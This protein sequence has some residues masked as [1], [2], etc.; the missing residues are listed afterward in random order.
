[1]PERKTDM[2]DNENATPAQL[3]PDLAGYPTPEAL[4]AGYRNSS[5][6]GKRQRERAD[7]LEGMLMQRLEQDGANHRQSVPD[8][9]SNPEERLTQFGVPVD[10]LEAY[11]GERINR[12][13]APIANGMQARGRIVAD[14]PDY[15]QFETDVAQFIANDA[16]LSA[17]YPKMFEA[18]PAGAME[19]AFLK[20]GDSRRREVT[21]SSNGT[22]GSPIDA[23][24]PGS[25][26]GESRRA[27]D[28]SQDLRTAYEKFAQT[29]SSK[30]AEAYAKLRLRSVIKDSFLNQ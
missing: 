28:N 10:A 12:A 9:N 29:G 2:P 30:D 19:Y 7:K 4:V 26:G 22:V 20:F 5:D 17:R 6:E 21:S 27:P 8:R 18:D 15:V 16:D 1:M 25:R 23:S 14:H 3:N 13:F 24:I 11:V